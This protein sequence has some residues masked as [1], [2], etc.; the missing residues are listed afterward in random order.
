MSVVLMD[1]VSISGKKIFVSKE[2]SI[3]TNYSEAEKF[4]NMKKAMNFLNSIPKPLKR[5]RFTAIY[6]ETL[7]PTNLKDK[8]I[9]LLQ[10]VLG[11]STYVK[12]NIPKVNDINKEDET[13]KIPP[14]Y[15]CSVNTDC[16]IEGATKY[17]E[18]LQNYISEFKTFFNKL[19]LELAEKTEQLSICDKKISSLNH[20][21]E[22]YGE[23][24]NACEH[25]KISNEIDQIV[26]KR[27]SIKNEIAI[28]KKIKESFDMSNML[29]K[30][31]KEYED[32]K[33]PTYNAEYYQDWFKAKENRRSIV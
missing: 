18:E 2:R 28:G 8:D 21:L 27:R 22:F 3:T 24:M 32:I 23:R 5:Y 10:K 19:T 6:S 26:K 29:K 4:T 12:A 25:Y 1:S 16:S 17:I 9:E 11:T 15:R 7:D 20:L 31:I 13:I 30:V 14:I 33:H